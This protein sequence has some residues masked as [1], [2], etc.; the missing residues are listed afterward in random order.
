MG[1]DMDRIVDQSNVKLVPHLTC[2]LCM[3]L[4]EDGKQL[5]AC[6]HLFCKL[7]V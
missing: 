3:E 4:V 1:I 2:G 7:R 6:F 5:R